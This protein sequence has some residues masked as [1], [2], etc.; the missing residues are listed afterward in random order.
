MDGEVLNELNISLLEIPN[1]RLQ[2]FY[3]ITVF[4]ADGF[5]SDLVSYHMLR[6]LNILT[7]LGS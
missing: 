5:G 6:C 2:A 3:G 7:L 1:L 4:T